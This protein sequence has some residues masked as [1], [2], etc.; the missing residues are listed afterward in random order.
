MLGAAVLFVLCLFRVLDYGLTWDEPTYLRFA[1]WQADWIADLVASIFGSSDPSEVLSRERI[2]RAWLQHPMHNGHPPL[3][4]TWMGVVG[5]QIAIFGVSDLAAMRAS[6]ALLFAVAV[7]LFYRLLRTGMRTLAAACGVLLFAG[8]PAIWA[9]AHLGATEIMQ[10]FFWIGLALTLPWAMRGGRGAAIVWGSMC[11]LAFACKFTNVL[12]IGWALGTMGLLGGWRSRRLWL[13]ALVGIGSAFLGLLVLDPFFWPWQGGAARYL[14]YLRQCLSRAD[15]IPISVFYMG[16][17]WGFD[18]PWHYRI[19]E[20]VTTLPLPT[21]VLFLIG[22][23]LGITSF[24]RQVRSQKVSDWPRAV[25]VSCLGIALGLGLIPGAPDHDITRQF[26]FIYLA[27]AILGA[28]AVETLLA[29]ATDA[30]RAAIDAQRAGTETSRAAIDAQRAGAETSRA[31]ANAQR[32]GTGPRRARAEA[33]DAGNEERRHNSVVR[34]RGIMRA[35]A[36]VLAIAAIWS[37]VT[38]LAAEP[39]GLGYR[40][41]LLGGWRGAWERGFEISYWGEAI[42]PALLQS[43][44]GL[45]R[46]DGSPARILSIP[47]LNYFADAQ[48]LWKPLVD[49]KTAL[50]ER[51]AIDAMPAFHERWVTPDMRAQQEGALRMTFREPIDG[52]L[53]FWRRGSVAESYERVLSEL[54]RRGDLRLVSD[55]RVGGGSVGR[56]YAVERMSPTTLAGDPERRTWYRLGNAPS[57]AAEKNPGQTA[58]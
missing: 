26:V 57:S 56:L 9:H 40:N 43:V 12:A 17:N 23:W 1:R 30:R 8:V 50:G 24:W 28:G 54:E 58:P 11:A 47:K 10:C 52:V 22:F 41:A 33:L 34:R 51:L 14:D 21:L 25:G 19:V 18:P 13:L 42:T 48:D 31:R 27:V 53:F 3:N 45:R 39:F 36:P 55:T 38:A 4:E 20:T 32:A 29:R 5:R 44:D 49:S 2:A 7:F 6:I 46:P 15:W 37:F 16:R 35:F